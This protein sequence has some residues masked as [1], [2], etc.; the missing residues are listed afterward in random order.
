MVSRSTLR[1]SRLAQIQQM[2]QGADAVTIGELTERLGVSE[3]TVRRD[4]DALQR[5]GLVQRTHGGAVSTVHELPYPAR[6][7][8]QVLEKKAIARAAAAMVNPGDTIFIGGGSTTL[9]LAELLVD[10]AVTV[11]TN[12]I[13]VATEL[14]R[15]RNGQV[16]VVGGTVRTPE[17]SLIGP[18][19]VDGIRSYRAGIAFL[20]VPALDSEHGFTADGDVEA[21]TDSAFIDMAQRTVV[22]AD[23]TKL[24]RVS[25]RQV[26]PLDALHTVITDPGATPSVIDELSAAGTQVIVAELS[27]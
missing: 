5:S 24:G 25:T 3:A 2:L 17:L 22:L 21:A 9:R 1:V 10:A 19:A 11:V 4:L 14:A 20:G 16:I 13:P 8:L 12:S 23:H 26:V 18:R 27:P 15:N 7:T 6:N